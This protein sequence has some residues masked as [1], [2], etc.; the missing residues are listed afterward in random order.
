MDVVGAVLEVRD[1]LVLDLLG[2]QVVSLPLD[3]DV[4]L[5]HSQAV[6]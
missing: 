5:L 1:V 6:A 3:Q 4:N 2:E